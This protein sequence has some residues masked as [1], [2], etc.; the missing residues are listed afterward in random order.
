MVGMLLRHAAYLIIALSVCLERSFV[1]Q[2]GLVGDAARM[3]PGSASTEDL[4][5][6]HESV[7]GGVASGVG[8]LTP[9]SS[10]LSVGLLRNR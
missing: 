2:T 7:N 10:H 9:L 3:L 1:V 6:K 5:D 8:K 4:G